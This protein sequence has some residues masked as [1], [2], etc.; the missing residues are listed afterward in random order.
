MRK[1]IISGKQRWPKVPTWLANISAVHSPDE[2]IQ[3]GAQL[4]Y[5]SGSTGYLYNTFYQSITLA[6]EDFIRTPFDISATA[7]LNLHLGY[8][9]WF[10][11]GEW[12]EI[13]VMLQNAHDGNQREVAGGVQDGLFAD[14]YRGDP[15]A[16][17]SDREPMLLVVNGTGELIFLKGAELL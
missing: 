1:R 2:G 6:K 4:Y 11:T 7:T 13:G 16:Y 14:E 5:T 17:D 3:F 8:K 12:M 10:D 15:Y 9:W